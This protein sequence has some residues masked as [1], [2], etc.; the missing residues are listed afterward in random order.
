MA[1]MRVVLCV[2]VSLLWSFS[3]SAEKVSCPPGLS[4]TFE[5]YCMKPVDNKGSACP[6]GTT[7]TKVNVTGPM[8]CKGRW[9]CL[10]DINKVPNVIVTLREGTRALD[11]ELLNMAK[12]YQFSQFKT[13]RHV[14]LPQLHPFLMSA[15]R[16][17]IA[18]IWKIILMD[19]VIFR[20][21]DQ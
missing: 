1:F 7:M 3:A 10:S 11:K 14:I 5:G 6:P 21:C 15:T 13:L 16:S 9:K 19:C 8:I 18:L 20:C 2:V 4:W 12:S 17:G